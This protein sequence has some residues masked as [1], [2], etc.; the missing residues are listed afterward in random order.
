M[1]LVMNKGSKGPYLVKQIV[2]SKNAQQNN[3]ICPQVV[4]RHFKP[5]TNHKKTK[6]TVNNPKNIKSQSP[7]CFAVCYIARFWAYIKP[8]DPKPNLLQVR[9]QVSRQQHVTDVRANV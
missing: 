1:S 2:S 8:V 6:D 9:S 7:N 5:I 3:G 4:I